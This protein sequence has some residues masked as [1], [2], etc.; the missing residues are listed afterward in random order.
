MNTKWILMR[1]CHHWSYLANLVFGENCR[2]IG[3]NTS[4]PESIKWWHHQCVS[5]KVM[6]SQISVQS[7]SSI[8]W[9]A[10]PTSWIFIKN[11][12]VTSSLFAFQIKYFHSP[13]LVHRA[14]SNSKARQVRSFYVAIITLCF[15]SPEVFTLIFLKFWPKKGS[16]STIITFVLFSP[17]C[18]NNSKTKCPLLYTWFY[19]WISL[20]RGLL[21]GHQ[22]FLTSL[23]TVTSLFTSNDVSKQIV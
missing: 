13:R 3:V 6:T 19:P 14:L 15:S 8:C 11:P 1:W 16:P 2:K 9:G 5:H 22:P 17:L 12:L 10:V 20:D 7:E 18:Q 21:P 4:G 23:Y